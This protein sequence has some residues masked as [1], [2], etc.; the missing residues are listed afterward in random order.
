M[1]QIYHINFIQTEGQGAKI[2]LQL[3]AEHPIFVGH[4]PS[5]PILPGVVQI[6][7]ARQ[8]LQVVLNESLLMVSSSTVKFTQMINPITD[9]EIEAVLQWKIED[10]I[11]RAQ[12]EF[13]RK[14]EPNEVLMKMKANYKIT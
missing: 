11:V 8:L 5:F 4:F 9:P 1:N 7:M 10:K 14:S 2:S 13:Q 6:E 3:K 12:I